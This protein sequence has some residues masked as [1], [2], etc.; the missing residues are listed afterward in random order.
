MKDT[1]E[2]S[3]EI[4]EE[5]VHMTNK[6]IIANWQNAQ[7][8]ELD[9]ILDISGENA[10]KKSKAH[11][12]IKYYELFPFDGSERVLMELEFTKPIVKILHQLGYYHV[13]LDFGSANDMDLRMTYDLI[14]R[15]EKPASSVYW[16]PEE[17]ES[18][19]YM[20]EEGRQR[21]IYYPMVSLSLLPIGKETIYQMHG[22]NPL[23]FDLTAGDI[24]GTPS[25][26]HFVFDENTFEIL[27]QKIEFSMNEIRLEAEEEL[28][29]ELEGRH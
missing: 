25:V 1:E 21:K 17:I 20:D 14:K 8:R 11:T 7:K 6:Q 5:N 16:L 13:Y 29:R 19:L 24:K 18:G 12:F 2:K 15:Y 23:L 28:R 4:E 3:L 27:D 26:M 9:Y 10:Q 22:F